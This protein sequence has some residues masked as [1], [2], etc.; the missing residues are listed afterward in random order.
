[1]SK[2]PEAR[3]F[4]CVFLGNSL[5]KDDN[6]TNQVDIA[7]LSAEFPNSLNFTLIADSYH[8]RAYYICQF[9]GSLIVTFHC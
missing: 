3:L 2:F 9:T 4:C 1:L 8:L 5:L 7:A 6:Q